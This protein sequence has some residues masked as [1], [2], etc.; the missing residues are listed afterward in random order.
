MARHYLYVRIYRNRLSI[1]DVDQGREVVVEAGQ[2]FSHPRMLIGDTE[3]LSAVLEEGIKKLFPS[4]FFKTFEILIHPREMLEGGFSKVETK[5]LQLACY[6]ASTV[7]AVYIWFKEEL[8]DTM[9][10]D[11]PL[12]PDKYREHFSG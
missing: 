12:N 1:R 4:T 9:A 8:D 6:H 2:S 3:P 11:I 7:R 5:A 10:R